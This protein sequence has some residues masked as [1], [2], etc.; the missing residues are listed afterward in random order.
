MVRMSAS[1]PLGLGGRRWG[2]AAGGATVLLGV[3]LAADRSLSAWAQ[4]WPAPLRAGL[5]QLTVLGES[6]LVLYPA[7]ALFVVTAALALIARRALMRTL[8]GQFAAL[9][10]FIF[11]GVG[12]P[13]LVT[14]LAK[15]LIGRSRPE[16]FEAEGLLSFQPNWADWSHQSFPSGH[17]TTAFAL[18]VAIGFLAPRWFYPGLLLAGAIAVSRVA[19]GAHYPSDVLAGAIVGG[20]GAYAARRVFAGRGWMFR[21]D[22]QGGI[23]AR[24]L[25]SLARYGALKRRGSGR[26]PRRGRP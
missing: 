1:W 25:A 17:A 23:A 2:L 7:V 4:D 5:E 10:A 16:L 24:P 13:V 21:R 22:R 9:S 20:L 26:A 14:A 11:A 12:L 6:R 18:A 19:L 8:L 15:R 3:A